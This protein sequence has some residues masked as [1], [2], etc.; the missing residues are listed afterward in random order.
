MA[1]TE[2][3]PPGCG[4]VPPDL[5]LRNRAEAARWFVVHVDRVPVP[6]IAADGARTASDDYLALAEWWAHHGEILDPPES[7]R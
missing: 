1:R 3:L 7:D 6:A 5:P 4:H 2:P